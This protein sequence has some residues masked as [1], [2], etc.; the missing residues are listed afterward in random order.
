LAARALK[1][2]SKGQNRELFPWLRALCDD[3]GVRNPRVATCWKWLALGFAFGAL[4]G[5]SATADPALAAEELKRLQGTWSVVSAEIE[6]KPAP[7]LRGERYV[8]SGNK[9]T[10]HHKERKSESFQTWVD[11]GHEP[12]WISYSNKLH[13]AYLGVYEVNNDRLQLSVTNGTI[14]PKELNSEEALFLV[15]ERKR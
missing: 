3:A 14:R 2:S 6:E 12:K 1:L 4:L 9:L 13:Q 7:Q 5:A 10:I 8:F 15:L 11:P